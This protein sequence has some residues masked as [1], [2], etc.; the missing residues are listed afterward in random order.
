MLRGGMG[1]GNRFASVFK[2]F[3]GAD[4]ECGGWVPPEDVNRPCGEVRMARLLLWYQS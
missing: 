3:C 2:C 1:R 4:E